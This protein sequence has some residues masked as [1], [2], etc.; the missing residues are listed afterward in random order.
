MTLYCNTPGLNK[1][2]SGGRLKPVLSLCGEFTDFSDDEYPLTHACGTPASL[3]DLQRMSWGVAHNSDDGF[4]EDKYG[5]RCKENGSDDDGESRDGKAPREKVNKGKGRAIDGERDGDVFEKLHYAEEDSKNMKEKM[6]EEFEELVF[7]F[8]LGRMDEGTSWKPL[9]LSEVEAK[10]QEE[11]EKAPRKYELKKEQIPNLESGK[12]ESSNTR[13]APGLENPKAIETTEGALEAPS[14]G[15]SNPTLPILENA[16][17]RLTINKRPAYNTPEIPS[18]G[19]GPSSPPDYTPDGRYAYEKARHELNDIGRKFR[20][21]IINVK[22]KPGKYR[23]RALSE[24]KDMGKATK[25]TEV[26]HH[27]AKVDDEVTKKGEGSSQCGK[28]KRRSSF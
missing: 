6:D 4:I 16:M 21:L 13:T 1:I 25:G 14:A 17:S 19:A 22:S 23:K 10:E 26:E 5:G 9:S 3:K 20:D 8:K 2:S 27:E 18:S 15:P 7:K 11:S 28:K 24:A 12:T